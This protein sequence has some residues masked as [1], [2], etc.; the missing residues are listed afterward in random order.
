MAVLF[1][2][3]RTELS[4]W[5]RQ[6]RQVEQSP[7]Q[8]AAPVPRDRA[9]VD[10]DPWR[11]PLNHHLAALRGDLEHMVEPEGRSTGS[12]LPDV[13]ARVALVPRVRAVVQL[14]AAQAVA[15][16]FMPAAHLLQARALRSAG[17]EISPFAQIGPGCA[18]C[19]PRA[20]SSARPC[21]SA[22]ACG[23]TRTSRSATA[24]RRVSPS[25]VTT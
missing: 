24:R 4:V 13:L 22:A 1:V 11:N 2:G 6:R 21:A 10:P 8:L 25:S 19:T 23:S 12:W 3:R 9:V 14:R 20:S 5:E 7:G 17:A 18:S 15:P 16:R